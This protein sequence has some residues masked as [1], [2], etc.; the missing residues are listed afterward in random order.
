MNAMADILDLLG[1]S[2]LHVFHVF[3]RIGAMASLLPAF[4][5]QSIP[6]RIKLAIAIALTLVVAPAVTPIDPAL[7]L[8]GFVW[9]TVTETLSGLLL[10]IGMRLFVFA[11]QTAGSMAAQS[12][13][14]SQ[15]FGQA[16]TDPMPAMSHVLTLA[17]LTLAVTVGLHV[18]V[19]ELAIHSYEIFPMGRLPLAADLGKWGV[20]RVAETFALAFRLAAPFLIVSTLYN[21]ALGVINRAMPQLMVAF[22]GAP[23]ITAGGLGLL[24]VVSGSLLSLWLE[25]FLTFLAN[26]TGA[27]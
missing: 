4:G 16:G 9:I 11:L 18:R 26:P 5:E 22:V 23:L 6:M 13:S 1:N 19:A 2:G 15:L 14:L 7:G 17:G 8:A 3:L 20:T 12:M 21:L 10:G 27:L 24:L 25:L